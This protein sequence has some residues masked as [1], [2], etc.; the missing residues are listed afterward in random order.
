MALADDGVLGP[1]SRAAIRDAL[2]LPLLAAL[3]SEAAG[4]YRGLVAAKP[5]FKRFEAGWLN[6]AYD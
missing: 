1:A 2:Q 3:R 5:A 6:R 4:F